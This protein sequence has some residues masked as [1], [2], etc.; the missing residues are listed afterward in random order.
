[1]ITV[2]YPRV[3][4]AGSGKAVSKFMGICHTLEYVIVN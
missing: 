3:N 1:M 2:P 4:H